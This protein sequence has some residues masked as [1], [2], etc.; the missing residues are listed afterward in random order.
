MRKTDI[1][2]NNGS[3]N[4]SKESYNT[5]LERMNKRENKKLLFSLAGFVVV[6]IAVVVTSFF[7]LN[8]PQDVRQYAAETPSVN[9]IYF[10]GKNWYVQGAN[11][12]WYNWAC[13][14]GCNSLNGKSGGV[15]TNT[16]LLTQAFVTAKTNGVNVLRWWV[17]PGDAW[18]ITRDASGAPAGIDPSVYKDFDAA[19]AIAEQ[20][21]LYF[22]FMLFSSP[23]AIPSS[24]QTD[25]TQRTKLSQAL[26]TLFAHYSGNPHILSWEIYNEPEFDVWNGKISQDAVVSTGKE[27]AQSVHTNSVGT[28]VTVGNAFADGMSMWADAGLDYYSPHWYDYMSSGEYCIYCHNYSFYASQGIT[29]P[30]VIGEFYTGDNTTNPTSLQRYNYWYNSGFAGAWGWSLFPNQT[31]DKLAVDLAASK[32]FA[33]THTDIGP[34]TVTIVPNTPIPTPTIV[35]STPTN[36]PTPSTIITPTPTP[37]LI[38]TP[39]PT[40]TPIPSPSTGDTTSPAVSITAPIAGSRV[41]IKTNVNITANASDNVGVLRVEFR[42]GTTL[43]CTDTTPAYSCTWR[44]PA[45]RNKT[46]KITAKAV[47][48]SGNSSTAS[49]SVTSR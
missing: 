46:Y 35:I 14:F 49:I 10:G 12:P 15:S 6:F 38:L 40:N 16:Q 48:T 8:Q 24:W 31:S 21:D 13:D 45:T 26:G 42:V 19:L 5:I 27:I 1:V 20:N 28:L 33:S 32:T 37:T 23:T 30:I 18:Q 17:F 39:I 7:L 4:T 41:R 11:V 22:N 2:E 47:D 29:K 3:K 9:R 25:P 44:V 34:V 36:I 43:I